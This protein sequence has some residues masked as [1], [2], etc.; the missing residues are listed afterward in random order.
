MK[1]IEDDQVLIIKAIKGDLGVKGRVRHLKVQWKIHVQEVG[2]KRAV[3]FIYF[4]KRQISNTNE[5]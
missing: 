5:M 2:I 4:K 3:S 1:T